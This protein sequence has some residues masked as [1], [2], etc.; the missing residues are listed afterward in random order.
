VDVELSNRDRLLEAAISMI[1]GGGEAA[2]RVDVIADTA[3]VTKP[4]IYH[5]FG[6][7]DGLVVAAQAERY[8]RSLA[9]GLEDADER[10]EA[11]S[12]R[13]EFMQIVRDWMTEIA[14]P[15]GQ[16]RRR[17]RVEVLGSA[18]S[19]PQLRATLDEVET[20]TVQ[21][22]AGM[23]E[24]ARDRG[25]VTTEFDLEVLSRWWYGMMNGRYLVEEVQTSLVR[26][27]WDAIATAA[28]LTLLFGSDR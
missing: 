10:L 11:C 25:W 9:F 22:L 16:E 3:G 14:S 26:R 17:V 15:E 2:L 6:G 23:L 12:S 5:H 24:R 20:N 19:R 7:R 1:E 21:A 28:T 4:S 18:A 27:E 13:T 8:R